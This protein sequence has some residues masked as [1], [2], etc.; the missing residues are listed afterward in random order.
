MDMVGALPRM[1]RESPVDFQ[2]FNVTVWMVTNMGGH[3]KSMPERQDYVINSGHLK[4]ST[5]SPCVGAL[6][7]LFRR[8]WNGKIGELKE[9][10]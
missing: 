8:V 4:D 3:R 1:R 6:Q 10:P 7:M 9:L 2:V 5:P